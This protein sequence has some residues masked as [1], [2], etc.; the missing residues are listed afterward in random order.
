MTMRP[1]K[2]K[3]MEP[4]LTTE[5]QQSSIGRLNHSR[6]VHVRNLGVGTSFPDSVMDKLQGQEYAAY[7]S[8][9]KYADT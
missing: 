8:I 1:K 5:P 4:T 2:G 7:I 3:A 9:Y 6:F